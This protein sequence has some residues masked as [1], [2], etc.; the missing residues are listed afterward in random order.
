VVERSGR[1]VA[2]AGC[3]YLSPARG[4][5]APAQTAVIAP[6]PAAERLVGKH[7]DRLDA[8]AAWGVPAHV[9]VLYPFVEPAAANEQ[10]VAALA[11]AVGSDSAF[12]CRFLR[13]RWFGEDVLWLDPE[14]AQPFRQLTAAVWG[15]FPQ[16]PPY[17][18]VHD[19]VIPHLTVA[20]RRMADLPAV[21]AAEGA[22][23]P[24]LPLSTRISGSCSSPAPR[25]PGPG[26]C[27][28]SCHSALPGLR[29]LRPVPQRDRQVAR[30]ARAGWVV[31]DLVR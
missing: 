23:Q 4:A 25:H 8:A 17:R 27:F 1:L 21:R 30:S 28:T 24:G 31:R 14:P 3:K 19:D 16:Y 20:E 5:P 15:A 6:V 9:T 12:D 13:T 26:E 22:V 7:R 11:A 29:T 18:G 10:L 2:S